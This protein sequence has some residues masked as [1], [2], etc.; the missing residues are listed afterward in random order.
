MHNLQLT[1]VHQSYDFQQRDI[2]GDA[3]KQYVPNI[4]SCMFIMRIVKY[5]YFYYY[6]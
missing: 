6:Y 1:I 3:E 5:M 4:K 2:A